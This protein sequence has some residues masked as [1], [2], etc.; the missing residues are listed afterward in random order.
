MIEYSDLVTQVVNNLEI[1]N[2][3]TDIERFNIVANLNAVQLQLLNILPTHFISVAVRTVKFNMTADKP[4]YQWPNEFVRYVKMWVDYANPITYTNPGRE[5]TV[6]NPEKHH[7]PITDIASENFPFIDLDIERGFYLAPIPNTSVTNGIRLRYVQE[8]PAISDTQP[9]LLDA[10]FKNL[11]V[12]GASSLS[13][14]V[15]N[16]RPELAKNFQDLFQRELGPFMPKEE[17]K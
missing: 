2:T 13:A 4:D 12:F 6:W 5:V 1:G 10:R 17:K 16:Y 3:D 11:L 15:D 7:L 9:S 14:L 8:L